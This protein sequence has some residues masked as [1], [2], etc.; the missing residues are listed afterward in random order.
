M[1]AY[2]EWHQ[3]AMS[4]SGC[5]LDTK[6]SMQWRN[7]RFEPGG[8]TLTKRGHY[9]PLEQCRRQLKQNSMASNKPKVDALK[10]L[11]FVK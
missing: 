4:T 7:L 3:I 6:T 11:S 5:L 1:I 10:I 8:A 2:D 9:M